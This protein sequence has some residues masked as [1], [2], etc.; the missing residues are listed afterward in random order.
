MVMRRLSQHLRE[1]NWTAISIEFVLLVAGVFLGIQVANWNEARVDREREKVFLGQLRDEIA[2]NARSIRHQLDYQQQ[3]VASGRRV[4]AFLASDGRCSE[5]CAGLIID[6][7]HASQIWGTPYA[8]IRY[9]ENQ[10]LGFPSDPAARAA[11]DAFYASIAGWDTVTATLPAYR[12]RVRGHLTPDASNTL[13]RECWRATG[14]S[15]ETLVRDCETGIEALDVQAML[16]TMHADVELTRGLNFW[17]GQNLF[18]L[19]VVPE[20]LDYADAAF[21]AIDAD[22]GRP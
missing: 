5:G 14:A 6:F 20:T 18:S 13:W 21:S 12:E 2:E 4:L 22:L 7:F 10:R 1:Q 17:V 15:F 11:I 3:V 19:S 8:R 9:E 16:A